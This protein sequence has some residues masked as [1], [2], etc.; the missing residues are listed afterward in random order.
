MLHFHLKLKVWA[1]CV[2]SWMMIKDDA[3]KT[4]CDQLF[5]FVFCFSLTLSI[6]LSLS[7]L[8]SSNTTAHHKKK[9]EEKWRAGENVLGCVS[10]N[11]KNKNVYIWI[12]NFF[13]LFCISSILSRSKLSW[14]VTIV[15]FYF[16]NNSSFQSFSISLKADSISNRNFPFG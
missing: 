9:T 1:C 7:L 16:S 12:H 14:N 4:L 8:P 11:S 13:L 15:L 5:F 6:S 10:S 3:N 2:V